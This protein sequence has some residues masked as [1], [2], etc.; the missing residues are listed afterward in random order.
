MTGRP[1]LR[2]SCP[3]RAGDVR[4]T[5]GSTPAAVELA[6][7]AAGRADRV[8]Q[9]LRLLGVKAAQPL[10]QRPKRGLVLKVL[11]CGRTMF[12]DEREFVDRAGGALRPCSPSCRGCGPAVSATARRNVSMRPG[13]TMLRT[14]ATVSGDSAPNRSVCLEPEAREALRGAWIGRC[15]VRAGDALGIRLERAARLPTS[16]RSRPSPTKSCS[17]RACSVPP[18]AS[19]S[20]RVWSASRPNCGWVSAVGFLA[21]SSAVGVLVSSSALGFLVS[22]SV[23]GL[24]VSSSVL[25]LF[26]SS[27]VGFRGSS[28]VGFL[29]SSEC[30]AGSS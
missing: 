17:A 14:S 8:D 6:L 15:R 22:S 7:L 9:R 21:S 16:L 30:V 11:V 19:T 1:C 3:S 18:T 4:R 10:E 26:G 27:P 23:P 12:V 24:F 25:G 28:V 20:F 13:G 5:G 2:R 29:G